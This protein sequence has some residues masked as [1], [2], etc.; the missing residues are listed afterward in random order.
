M[1]WVIWM[2]IGKCKTLFLAQQ[3]IEPSKGVAGCFERLWGGTFLLMIS[4]KWQFWVIGSLAALN[5][6]SMLCVM[7][8]DIVDDHKRI[9]SLE[10]MRGTTCVWLIGESSYIE[11]LLVTIIW[12]CQVVVLIESFSFD[13]LKPFTCQ[14]RTEVNQLAADASMVVRNIDGFLVRCKYLTSRCPLLLFI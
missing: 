11:H 12:W 2:A 14:D 9:Y 10:G 3:Q 6:L 5:C 8:S 13:Q 7:S 1:A 4:V